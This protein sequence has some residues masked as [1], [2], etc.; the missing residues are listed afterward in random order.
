V[1]EL[2]AHRWWVVPVALV[3]GVL[4]GVVA[5]LVSSTSRKAEAS[6]LISSPGGLGEVTPFLSNLREL[7]TSGVLAGNV[8]S[9][10]RLKESVAELRDHLDADVRP[11]S[12]VIV[13]SAT[14]DD[15]EKARQL[16]QEAT[17]VFTQLVQSRFGE[18]SPPLQAALLD[19]AQVL[20]ASSRHFL[21]N[22]LIGG[23]VGLVLGLLAAVLL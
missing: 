19:S 2:R 12:Q 1:D 20:S 23:L 4:V 21:R 16:A 11:Q 3:V 10:L 8:R 14:D 5:S 9:T 17:V 22:A 6:V 13:I 15:A 7:A 18:R